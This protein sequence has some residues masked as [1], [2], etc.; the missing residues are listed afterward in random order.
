MMNISNGTMSQIVVRPSR[1]EGQIEAQPSKSYTHR[2]LAI[3]LLADGESRI[4]NPLLSLDTRSSVEAVQVLGGNV[5]E[6]E[7]GWK[8]VG[9]R[10]DIRPKRD[11]IDVRNSGTTLRLMTGVSALSSQRIRLTGDE[12]IVKRPM[13]PLI[14]SLSDLGAEAKCEGSKGR[15]PVVVGGGL[16]GG[17]TQITG[18]VSSQ[19][20]S[21]LLI[22]TPYSEV[23]VDLEVEDGLKSKPYVRMTLKTLE[24]ANVEVDSSSSLMDYSIPGNQTFESFDYSV[25]G[26]FSSAAFL[27]GAAALCKGEVTVNGLDPED[28]QG[29]RKILDLL[30]DFGADLGIERKSV[31]VRGG[32]RLSGIDVDCSDIPDLIP[33]LAVL[34]ARAEGQT[35]LYNASH[36]RYKEV[37]RLRVLSSELKKMGADIEEMEDGL[38][39]TGTGRLGGGKVNSYGDHRMAMAFA[40]AGLASRDE[41]RVEGAES[42]KISYPN[43]VKDMRSLGAKMETREVD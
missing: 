28:V 9:T 30:K 18:T 38:R 37:D 15:P 24:L 29:D 17:E 40:I 4:K 39:I 5:K 13:G 20:I 19:F 1:I 16:E 14:K 27:L 31:T 25:P 7:D 12:S 43:F 11:Y 41:V 21:A 35:R 3:G 6:I 2:L 23:G 10:G 32:K 26:D 33:V 34:G 36:L 22:A 8:V 42:T